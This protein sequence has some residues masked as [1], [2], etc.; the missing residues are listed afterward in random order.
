MGSG[1]TSIFLEDGWAHEKY[2][3]WR[4]IYRAAGHKVLRKRYG[5]FARLLILSTDSSDSALSQM[6]HQQ[7]SG[8][9]LTAI[10]IHDFSA[11]RDDV[12]TVA[13][14]RFTREDPEDTLLNTATIVLDLTQSHEV[15]ETKLG[16]A[17][18]H[19]LRSAQKLGVHAE[20]LDP[21][22][23]QLLSD[24]YDFYVPLAQRFKLQI[25]EREVL[26]QMAHNG[27]LFAVRCQDSSQRT[28]M[29]NLI[30]RASPTHAIFLYGARR[31]GKYPAGAGLLAHWTAALYLKAALTHWYDLGGIVS[32]SL[33]DGIYRFKKSLGGDVVDLGSEFLSLP[34]SMKLV[35]RTR[36]VL[37][38]IRGM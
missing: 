1:Y 28:L 21:P 9:W 19:K 18:R 37:N 20:T 15:L 16:Q 24:F 7:R 12:P 2:Y 23:D 27:D 35:L 38:S 8:K 5:P 6:L 30:Y 13:G 33:D 29:V 36:E 14:R 25:P 17:S 32:T 11:L 26:S 34:L 31:P 3:G 4:L 10:S 22:D